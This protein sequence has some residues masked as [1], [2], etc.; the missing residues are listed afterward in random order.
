MLMFMFWLSSDATRRDEMI[1]LSVWA[2]LDVE[3]FLCSLFLHVFIVFLTRLSPHSSVSV[4]PH[5]WSDRFYSQ[6][7]N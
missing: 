2:W 4:C 5:C 7:T 3:R 1:F 6:F